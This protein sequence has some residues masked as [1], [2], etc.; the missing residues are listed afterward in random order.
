MED[1]CV[2][3]DFIKL[4]GEV[5]V[6]AV[7]ALVDAVSLAVLIA[8]SIGI[9]LVTSAEVDL[10]VAPS[11]FA[12]GFHDYFLGLRCWFFILAMSLAL[13]RA[14]VMAKSWAGSLVRALRALMTSSLE[15]WWR[16]MGGWNSR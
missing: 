10:D 13:L 6:V 4:G 14:W 7:G 1:L 2:L 16:V 9:F 11:F 3:A 8:K 15:T 12:G 5:V